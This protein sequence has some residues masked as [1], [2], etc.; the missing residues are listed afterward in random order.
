MTPEERAKR[1]T[2]VRVRVPAHMCLGVQQY[3]TRERTAGEAEA[4]IAS[5]ILAAENEAQA[6]RDADAEAAAVWWE[7]EQCCGVGDLYGVAARFRSLK[8]PPLAR[9]S[10]SGGQEP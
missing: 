5:A 2:C 1:I 6:K 7:R 9:P 3:T 4:D 10:E 8:S